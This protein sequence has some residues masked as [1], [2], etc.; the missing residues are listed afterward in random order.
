MEHP[1]PEGRRR[2]LRVGL[3]LSFVVVLALATTVAVV[4][5]GRLR[6]APP[7]ITRLSATPEDDEVGALDVDGGGTRVV[8]K[9]PAPATLRGRGA[10]G[11]SDPGDDVDVDVELPALSEVWGEEEVETDSGLPFA[12]DQLAAAESDATGPSATRL[13]ATEPRARVGTPARWMDDE[14]IYT[15]AFTPDAR[16]VVSAGESNQIVVREVATGYVRGRWEG[17]AGGV[18]DVEVSPDGSLVL[19]GGYDHEARLWD[20]ATGETL[21]KLEAG[22]GTVYHVGFVQGGSRALVAGDLGAVLLWDPMS[23]EVLQRFELAETG[24][25]ACL[26]PDGRTLAAVNSEGLLRVWD[27]SSGAVLWEKSAHQGSA[28]EVYPV[29]GTEHFITCGQDGMLRVWRLRDGTLV[30]EWKAHDERISEIA[31]SPNGATVASGGWGGRVKHWRVAGGTLLWDRDA[32]DDLV[33]AM[34][35]SKDGR[36]IGSGSRDGATRL[37]DAATGEPL[38]GVPDEREGHAG[39]ITDLVFVGGSLVSAGLDGTLRVWDPATLAWAKLVTMPAGAATSL[40][41]D[42]RG[43]PVLAGGDGALALLDPGS[44][45]WLWTVVPKAF[46]PGIVALD[47]RGGRAHAL[48]RG[49]GLRI[50]SA[51][52]G[53]ELGHGAGTFSALALPPSGG[54]LAL[55]SGASTLE[56]VGTYGSSVRSLTLGTSARGSALAFFPDEASL[57]VPTRTGAARVSAVDGSVL[58]TYRADAEARDVQVTPDGSGVVL[59]CESGMVAYFDAATGEPRLRFRGHQGAARCV[60]V[61]ADG[62][63]AASGGSNGAIY[64]WSLVH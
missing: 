50:H 42:P 40:D 53:A 49:G 16:L 10:G 19:S 47:A 46:R 29:P 22:S 57:L 41:A 54:L 24:N 51:A 2:L 44:G 56:F 26:A 28:G 21:R 3:L 52:T 64:L 8:A 25:G 55:R 20:F 37:W 58:A 33:V 14:P 30:R 31:V 7:E 5:V 34:A 62:R 43:G 38:P 11:S 13:P 36:T 12:P 18:S 15:V 32:H 60:A 6:E 27:V 1:A 59:A 39:A 63:T 9:K 17:H 4:G 35:F 61:S 48:E 23:G 45:T